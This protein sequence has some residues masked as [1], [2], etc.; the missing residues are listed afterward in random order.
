MATIPRHDPPPDNL[1]GHI[2]YGL[3]LDPEQ[4]AFRDAIYDSSKQ[5]V[6]ANAR[7]GTGKSTIAV[8][9]AILMC[10]YHLYDNIV[11][12]MHPY[13]D[14]QGFLPGTISEKSAV[15]FEALYQAIYASN[16][17][18]EMIITNDSM[19]NQ[20]AGT[21]FITAITSSYLRGSNIGADQKTILITDETQNF[22]EQNLRKVLT[23]ACSNTKVICIGHDGQ[24]DL[25]NPRRSAF[26]RCM[27]HFAS[28]NDDRV[29]ICSLSNNYRGFVSTVADEPWE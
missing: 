23:R 21:A 16:E 6:F 25:P 2:F 8:A 26:V 12:V 28:K 3:T 10:K 14:A 17:V 29:A 1:D 24:I 9:T 20:K 22:D 7:S 19:A 13:C 11:Y 5:I 18:P 15:W 4:T 27:N